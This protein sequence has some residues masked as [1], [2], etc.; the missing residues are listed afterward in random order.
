M[1]FTR[2]LLRDIADRVLRRRPP[3]VPPLREVEKIGGF[4]FLKVGEHLASIVVEQGGLR[5]QD[6]VLDI[7]CGLGRLAVGLRSHLTTGEYAGFDIYRRGIKWCRRNIEQKLPNFHFSFVDVRNRH[8][9]RR[10]TIEPEQFV[11]PYASDSFDVAFASSLFTH[12]TPGA[13]E[14]YVA[15]AGRVV[16]PGGRV[17]ASFFLINGETAPILD[18]TTPRFARVGAV[19]AVQDPDDPEAAVAYEEAAVREAFFRHG[20]EITAIDYGSW[21]FRGDTLSFQDFVVATKRA[22]AV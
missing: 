1:R 16:K 14:R 17:V 22:D 6:R 4:D 20:L 15:E 21:G 19:H 2:L 18:R 8:Y 10:G 9:N 7:G 12:L 11:F 5:P 3:F 13:V